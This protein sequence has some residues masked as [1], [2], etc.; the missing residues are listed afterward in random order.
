MNFNYGLSYF[1]GE[2]MG[3]RIADYLLGTYTSFK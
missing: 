1:K 2:A 3:E